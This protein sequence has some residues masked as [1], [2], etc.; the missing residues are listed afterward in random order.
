MSKLRL[1]G[2]TSGYEEIKTAD[3]GDSTTY[4]VGSTVTS[5]NVTASGTVSSANVTAS[6]TVTSVDVTASGTI[7]DS[8]GNVRALNRVSITSTPYALPADSTGKYF[9]MNAGSSELTLDSANTGS[10]GSIITVFKT[11]TGTATISWT[12]MT[13]GVYIAGDAT[14][15]GSS[16]SVTLADKGLVTILTEATSRLIFSGNVS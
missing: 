5:V 7:Q 10:G 11:S 14:N 4:Q 6:D 12:N 15:L 1:Y 13:N 9:S 3:T 16:G 2:A 8:Q